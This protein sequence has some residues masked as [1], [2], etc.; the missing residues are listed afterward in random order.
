MSAMISS[1]HAIIS[2]Y[3]ALAYKMSFQERYEPRIC[4]SGTGLF[5][6]ALNMTPGRKTLRAPMGA[7]LQAFSTRAACSLAR[8]RGGLGHVFDGRKDRY[9]ASRQS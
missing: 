3:G 9:R 6:W 2:D 4:F 5:R 8:M 1:F 7:M